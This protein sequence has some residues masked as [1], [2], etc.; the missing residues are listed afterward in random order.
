MMS[1]EISTILSAVKTLKSLQDFIISG[2][3][4]SLLD[5]I[6]SIHFEAAALA[7]RNRKKSTDINR[8]LELALGHLQTAHIAYRKAYI[9]LNDVTFNLQRRDA[10]DSCIRDQ[11]SCVL[12]SLCYCYLQEK[13]LATEYLKKAKECSK[14]YKKWDSDDTLF[15]LAANPKNLWKQLTHDDSLRIFHEYEL[16][17]LDWDIKMLKEQPFKSL[18]DGR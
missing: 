8:E 17:H 9:K 13:D 14:W 10:L 12:L 4:L 6:G 16:D 15:A 18:L 11:W 7:L 2:T 1:F 3:F 5:K